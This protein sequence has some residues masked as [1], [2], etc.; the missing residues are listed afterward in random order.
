M[1]RYGKLSNIIRRSQ[2]S[3]AGHLHP[4]LFAQHG[5]GLPVFGSDPSHS[6]AVTLD[7]NPNCAI[8]FSLEPPAIQLIPIYLKHMVYRSYKV[9]Q[10]RKSDVVTRFPFLL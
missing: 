10:Y 6:H 8:S 3:L 1:R 9:H 2:P 5:M 7:L 4:F